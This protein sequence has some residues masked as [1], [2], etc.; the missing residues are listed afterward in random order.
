MGSIPVVRSLP[1]FSGC[2]RDT[3]SDSERASTP[4]PR[5]VDKID[6]LTILG[7]RLHREK[8]KLQEDAN[9]RRRPFIAVSVV[10]G[11]VV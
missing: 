8:Q 2:F 4:T 6:D 7:T 3:Y 1:G 5:N 10:L 9:A 11:S